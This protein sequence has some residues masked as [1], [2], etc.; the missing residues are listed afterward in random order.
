MQLN[1]VNGTACA[2]SSPAVIKWQAQIFHSQK[3]QEI[4]QLSPAARSSV[5]YKSAIWYFQTV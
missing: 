4:A 3:A 2:W 1:A 5:N